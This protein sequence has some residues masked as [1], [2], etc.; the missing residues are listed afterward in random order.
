MLSIRFNGN[1]FIIFIWRHDFG[2]FLSMAHFWTEIFYSAK[3]G[4][5]I[6]PISPS[7]S[8]SGFATGVRSNQSFH[9]LWKRATWRRTCL[10]RQVARFLKRCFDYIP[11]FFFWP[12]RFNCR[13]GLINKNI[14]IRFDLTPYLRVT[15]IDRPI[16]RSGSVIVICQRNV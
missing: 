3:N 7:L 15:K 5:T 1:S 11:I 12:T 9:F 14:L 6:P 13:S 8:R 2:A 16:F 4:L 10:F